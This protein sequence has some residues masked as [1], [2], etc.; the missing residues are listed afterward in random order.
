MKPEPITLFFKAHI[1]TYTRK[2][3]SVVQAHDDKRQA[4]KKDWR[5]EENW[6]ARTQGKFATY[7]LDQL[8]YVV[9][10]A[11]EAA[12]HAWAMGNEKKANQ[13][14]DEVHYALAEIRKRQQDSAHKGFQENKDRAVDDLRKWANKEHGQ[15]G[16]AWIRKNGGQYLQQRWGIGAQHAEDALREWFPSEDEQ[17]AAMRSKK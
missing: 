14:E 1:D 10:D 12:K 9:K 3:G 7:S 2:D 6:H 16:A 15:Y 13:Y 17:L 8:N 11:K 5:D 4:A